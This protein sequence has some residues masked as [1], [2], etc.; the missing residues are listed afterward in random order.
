M[1][2]IVPWL[3]LGLLVAACASQQGGSSRYYS[4]YEVSGSGTLGGKAAEAA[5]ASAAA[6]STLASGAAPSFDQPLQVLRAPQPEMSADDVDHNVSGE[7]VIRIQFN[8]AGKVEGATI[9]SSTKESLSEAVLA[10]VRQ[11]EISPVT[12]AG[13]P[14][15]VTARQTF[16][17]ATAR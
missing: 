4:V 7:V 14:Q 13:A 15:K 11:W 2:R 9:I 8:E 12:R 6:S 5:F 16:K 1:K 3:T 17:F 10:A